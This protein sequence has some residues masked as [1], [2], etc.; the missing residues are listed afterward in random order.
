M[1]LALLDNE[2]SNLSPA[3]VKAVKECLEMV[4][5]MSRELRTMSHLLHPP[6]LDEAGLESALNWYVHGFAERSGIRAV[7]ELP[8]KLGRLPRDLEVAIFR[9][10]QE[11]LT[12]VH[13]HSGSSVAQVR[14]QKD[15]HV[16]RVEV[17]DERKG[18]SAKADGRH[19]RP[20]VGI[21]GMRERV[22]QLGGQ[23]D[24]RSDRG[25]T[26]VIATFSIGTVSPETETGLVFPAG[27]V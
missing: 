12:N 6:L 13:R 16:V 21:Q 24:I 10:V 27:F 17:R 23:L 3:G 1:N 11:C 2:S 15:D 5:E 25:G 9:I 20:G 18:V 22:A 26:S 8:P 14:L 19:V 4:R 7:L